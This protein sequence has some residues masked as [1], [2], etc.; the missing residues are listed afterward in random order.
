M[1]IKHL[2]AIA[3]GSLAAI[4]LLIALLSLQSLRSA[5][6]RLHGYLHGVDARALKVAEL[7]KA[8]DERALAARNLVLVGTESDRQAELAAVKQS[9]AE[10]GQHLAALQKLVTDASDMSPQARQLVQD[11]ADIEAR[12]APVALAVTALAAAGQREEAIAKMVRECRPLLADLIRA[13]NAYAKLTTE[14]AHALGGEAEQALAAQQG[15]LA[16]VCLLAL[17]LAG[18]AGWW[19]TRQVARPL[20]QAVHLAQAVAAGDLTQRIQAT[21]RDEVS[22]L[23]R[24]LAS[25]S[26]QLEQLIG[27]VRSSSAEINHGASEVALGAADLSQRTERQAGALQET[28][29]SMEELTSTVRQ[30]A[31]NAR[32]AAALSVQA[33]DVAK[34]GGV[35]VAEV[36][37]TMHGIESSSRR[38]ADILSVIDGIAFQTNILALNAAVE[39]ARAGEQGRGFAV[40]AGEVR[41]LAQRSAEAAREIKGLINDSVQR[42]SQGS[43]LVNTAGG[44]MDEVVAAIQRVQQMVEAI[45]DASQQQHAGVAQLNSAVAQMDTSTQQNAALVEESAAA[46]ESLRQQS[47]RLVTALAHFRCSAHPA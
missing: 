4:V 17:V 24:A 31:D 36:V 38:I 19:V 21:G 32:E 13:S 29:S 28:A 25:M 1:K 37:S 23:L 47:D 12:Y 45:S 5:N 44:T 8:V 40:V 14:R 11:M 27:Q 7:R 43:A 42:V 20:G 9:H 39:A 22:D 15:W 26:G 3:F 30:N 10:V 41:T 35:T 34:R 33:A 2:L 46:A 16:G 6:H 18:G